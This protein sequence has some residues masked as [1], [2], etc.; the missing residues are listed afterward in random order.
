MR[1]PR[2]RR[3]RPRSR[4]PLDSAP[5]ASELGLDGDLAMSDPGS[6]D[7]RDAGT[8]R[9][10]FR[11][12]ALPAHVVT[13]SPRTVLSFYFVAALVF[14][15]LGTVIVAHSTKIAG[16]DPVSY[17]RR[18]EC[19][20]R[21]NKGETRNCLVEFNV[22]KTIR[23]PSYLYYS[24]TGFF[25]NARK[26]A[27]SV[28]NRQL[29]GSAPSQFIQVQF[30]QPLLYKEGSSRGAN[31]FNPAEFINPCGL[32]A[33]SQF[34]DTLKLCRD[35]L[36]AD[37]VLLRK[38]GIAWESDRTKKFRPGPPPLY[39][40]A[41]NARLQD[42]DFMVWMRLS[43][44]SDFDKLYR[45]IDTEIL[46]GTYYMSINSTYPVASYRGDKL[47]YISTMQWF[48]DRNYTL[49]IYC[50][51]VG[52]LALVIAVSALV[53]HVTNHRPPITQ[54]PDR[55]LR[56]LAKLNIAYAERQHT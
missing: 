55:M 32:T 51:I 36:C 53:W 34:N 14:I 18:I 27:R 31:G 13:F 38:Q 6:D 40:G 16:I 43:T 15:P 41:I 10:R 4:S 20:I 22:T 49:G 33:W 42:E 8:R 23:A 50:L 48:G 7:E 2:F 44:F 29:R 19:E 1:P 47:F 30:C 35:D 24:L 45:I 52:I 11:Q 12:Q 54:D 3:Q 17:G 56:E 5:A 28:S 25:Q 21:E 26:Y 9:S 39:T 37:Q 46:P